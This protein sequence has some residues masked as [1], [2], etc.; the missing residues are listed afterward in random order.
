MTNNSLQKI[1]PPTFPPTY[2]SATFS[3][4]FF[5]STYPTSTCEQRKRSK[6]WEA[7]FQIIRGVIEGGENFAVTTFEP[8]Y[9]PSFSKTLNAFCSNAFA[10]NI[11][12]CYESRSLDTFKLLSNLFYSYSPA[13]SP[14][15]HYLLDYGFVRPKQA[16]LYSS[17]TAL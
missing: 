10:G 4:D 1:Y 2:E 8:L 16:L 12:W 3:N 5:S 11:H 9:I 14:K 7:A 15:E 6:P 17:S 13:K